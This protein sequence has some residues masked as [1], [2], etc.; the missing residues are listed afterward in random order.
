M[1]VFFTKQI[2][3][4]HAI[5]DE[6]ESR[7]LIRVLR[8]KQDDPVDI[9][10]G[11]GNLFKG[12]ISLPDSRNTRIRITETKRKHLA[13]KYSLHL[14]I[15]PTRSTDRFEWFLEKATEIG[16]DE[17]TPILCTRSER[18]HIRH[19]RSGKIL[20]AAMK[21]SG[22]AYLPK[23]NP[24]LPLS[25]FLQQAEADN[26]FIAHCRTNPDDF[27]ERSTVPNLSWLILIGPEGDFTP[28]EVA[29]ATECNY[30]EINLGEAVYR[31]ETA[32]IMACQLISYLN[33]RK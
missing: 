10:D 32:G 18:K 28:Q 29:M 1:Q 7:H 21:Q 30:A 23:L 16:V 14:A 24:M 19:E 3:G 33:L 26:K 4:N 13:R 25:E 31:T 27:L 15:A 12:V 2:D 20:L 9:V 11:R 6:E 5:L 8:L 17:I 22:R